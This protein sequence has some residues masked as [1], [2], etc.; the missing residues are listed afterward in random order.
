MKLF[1]NQPL[2]FISDSKLEE[3]ARNL[4]VKTQAAADNSEVKLYSNVVD[5]FSALFDSGRQG[6]TLTEWLDQEKS[7]QIQKTLQNFV[8]EFHQSVLGSIEGWENLGIGGSLDLRNR[9]KK[10][11]AEVK[12]KH[13]TLNSEGFVSV[14]DKLQR[15]LDYDE[16]YKNYTAYFITIIPKTSTPIDKLFCP[17]ERGTRRTER[18]DLRIIDGK[19]FYKLATG[20]DDAM[21]LLYLRIPYILGKIRGNDVQKLLMG[22][23]TFHELFDR[24]YS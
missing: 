22:T 3:L 12:N 15:H 2:A 11:I 6:I 13:N 24:A 19:S 21:E 20:I 17:P 5:P 1:S 18:Q 14:Y 8:G 16:S 7:R 23:S 10:I 9:N 4:I